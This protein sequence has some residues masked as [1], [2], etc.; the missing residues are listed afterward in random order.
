M[1]R[2]GASVPWKDGRMQR[3]RASGGWLLATS[4]ASVPE[5]GRALPA[6]RT[7]IPAHGR[8]GT[9]YE[10]AHA[11]DGLELPLRVFR[12]VRPRVGARRAT[13]VCAV[14]VNTFTVP[15]QTIADAGHGAAPVGPPQSQFHGPPSPCWTQNTYCEHGWPLNP[16]AASAFV[17]LSA[18]V[19]LSAVPQ[20][21]P[22]SPA[23]NVIA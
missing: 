14:S 2:T 19:V 6:Y 5:E 23:T 18:F 8:L 15:C 11:E 22:M 17:A 3:T 1:R 4:G 9:L 20:P 10:P 12:P 13:G 16:V 7:V 21:A